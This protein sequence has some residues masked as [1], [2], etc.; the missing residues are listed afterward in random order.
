MTEFQG[1]IACLSLFWIAWIL[2]GWFF[3]LGRHDRR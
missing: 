2:T 3:D 1:W